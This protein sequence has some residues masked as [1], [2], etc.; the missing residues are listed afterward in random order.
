[1]SLPPILQCADWPALIA[2]L[3]KQPAW[4]GLDGLSLQLASAVMV[5]PAAI[6]RSIALRAPQLAQRDELSVLVIW[7]ESVDAVDRGRWYQ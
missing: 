2:T 1:M 6:A 4:R 7:A 5:A 3:A